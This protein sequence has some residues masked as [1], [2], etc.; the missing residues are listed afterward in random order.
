MP[1]ERALSSLQKYIYLIDV[2]FRNEHISLKE[3]MDKYET[4]FDS[5]HTLSTSAFERARKEISEIFY[6]DI[7]YNR[8]KGGYYISNKEDIKQ[9]ELRKWLIETFQVDNILH[10]NP[11][12]RKR[13]LLENVPSGQKHLM[14]IIDAINNDETVL[15]TYQ[16][17]SRD[18]EPSLEVEPHFLKLFKQRWY[19]VGKIVGSAEKRIFGLDRIEELT[20][21]KHKFKM[22]KNFDADDIFI[23][24]YGVMTNDDDFDKAETVVL[25]VDAKQAFYL[26]SLP[27]HHS[28]KEV[29]HNDEYSIF[30][31]YLC[32]AYDFR[33]KILSLGDETEVLEPTDLRRYMADVIGNMLKRYKE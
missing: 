32:P 1:T 8:S 27:L 14:L 4:D 16:S 10:K 23:N 15:L 31:F 2:I 30:S 24:C 20:K 33:Q 3:I 29:E 22:P 11:R 21:T 12:L 6:V 9:F 25:K 13:I 19:L 7:E 28:Q 18:K 17:F 26:R 5:G